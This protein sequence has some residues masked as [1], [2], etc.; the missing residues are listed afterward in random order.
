[1]SQT[2]DDAKDARAIID[3]YVPTIHATVTSDRLPR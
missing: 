2:D 1:M 3:T